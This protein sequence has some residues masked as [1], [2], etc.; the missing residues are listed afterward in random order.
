MGDGD[1]NVIQ[2]RADTSEF[3]SINLR[4]FPVIVVPGVMGT[5]L[6]LSGP[7]WDPDSP[8]TMGQLV[9]VD[10]R[11]LAGALDVASSGSVMVP[12]S[13]SFA[14]TVDAD[15]GLIDRVNIVSP[16]QTPS[17][18]YA[19]R[20]WGGAVSAF[21]GPLLRDLEVELN[22]VASY[23]VY[24][25]GYDWRQSNTISGAALAA[26]ITNILAK[27]KARKVIM[28]THSMGGLVTRAAMVAGAIPQIQGVVHCVMPAHGAVVAYRRFHTG[29]IQSLDGPPIK[30]PLPAPTTKE[31]ADFGKAVFANV[32][33]AA[34]DQILGNSPTS[35][36]FTQAGLRGPVEL[37]PSNEYPGVFLTAPPDAAGLEREANTRNAARSLGDVYTAYALSTPPGIVPSV[38]QTDTITVLSPIPLV[39]KNPN[40]T[41]AISASDVKGLQIAINGARAFHQSIKGVAH[42]RTAVL[43]GDAVA[44]SNGKL[45]GTLTDTA[46]SWVRSSGSGDGTDPQF[47][48]NVGET[49]RMAFKSER[50]D[51][52]V[53]AL[54]A[55]FR[56]G[57]A[58][59]VFRRA[60]QVEH[61]GCYGDA[62]FPLVV[63]DKVFRFSLPVTPGQAP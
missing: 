58:N 5:R 35:Y 3:D 4:V 52:T 23:P 47:F 13:A 2:K 8:G 31:T 40:P 7:N 29:A 25:A 28:V 51:G 53:P 22:K 59:V 48:R 61:G 21:Y 42:P 17:A 38:G 43:F 37:L 55:A 1:T 36:A 41:H 24:L 60:F 20:G 14:S 27:E 18:F 50:G 11:V 6:T 9:T 10:Q 63:A 34:L 12:L 16:G 15:Q 32:I 54:S 62:V 26:Q 56:A 49:T 44:G 57:G 19:T 46:F 30:L 45:A 39:I 33:A